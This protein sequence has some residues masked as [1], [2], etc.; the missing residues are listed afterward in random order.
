MAASSPPGVCEQTV[1]AGLLVRDVEE[2]QHEHARLRVEAEQGDHADPRGDRDVVVQQVEQ[3]DGADGRERHRRHHEHRLERRLRVRVEQ[4]EDEG[5]RDRH[6]HLQALPDAN[7]VLVLTAP[8]EHVAGRQPEAGSHRP[9]RLLDVAAHVPPDDVDVHVAGHE[10]VLVADHRRAV[11]EL[12]VRELAERDLGAAGDR[13]QHALQPAD[14]VPQ[15][16]RV[17]QV[18]RVAFPSLDRRGDVLAADGAHDHHLHL[19]DRQTIASELIPPRSEIHEVAAGDAFGEH[20]PRARQRPDQPFDLLANPLDLGQ[21]RPEHLDPHR[22][23]DARR[24]HVD[25][26][27]DRHRPRVGLPWNLQRAVH[28]VDQRLVGDP[29]SPDGARRR[30][31]PLGQLRLRIPPLHRAPL[32]LVLQNDRGLHHRERR[33]I[34]GRLRASGLPE[35]AFDF[36]ERL[37]DAVLRLQQLLRLRH[38]DSRQRRRHVQDRAFVERGHELGAELPVRPGSW[39]ARRPPRAR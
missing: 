5:E 25:S 26:R 2:Q 16:A 34:G 20:A 3:P 28:L 31:D 36:R 24:E 12:D 6:D 21:V 32:G 8:Q 7:H 39:P 15:F 18:H 17:A 23:P 29:V 19:L 27:L 38:G 10:A 14:V 1:P 37:Q 33:R 9:L 22:R 13:H 30:L 4:D 35:H 11:D